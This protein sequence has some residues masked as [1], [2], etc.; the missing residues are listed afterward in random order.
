MEIKL[1]LKIYEKRQF[2]TIYGNPKMKF[3]IVSSKIPI[4]IVSPFLMN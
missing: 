3:R 4:E 2:R 1:L